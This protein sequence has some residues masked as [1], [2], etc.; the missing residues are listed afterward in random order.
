MA[1][2]QWT[3][4]IGHWWGEPSFELQ[5]NIKNPSPKRLTVRMWKM[6]THGMRFHYILGVGKVVKDGKGILMLTCLVSWSV[7]GPGPILG[8][9]ASISGW[10]LQIPWRLFELLDSP[11]LKLPK[12]RIKCEKKISRSGDRWKKITHG[13]G[14]WAQ[15][16]LPWKFQWWFLLEP[17]LHALWC[18]QL[19]RY[20][21]RRTCSKKN[22]E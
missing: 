16:S 4:D 21:H 20:K 2:N 6:T 19:G 3:C 11:I 17:I 7:C 15:V 1:M 5:E 18:Q 8:V 9:P 10:M 14:L 12:F 13:I 22:K